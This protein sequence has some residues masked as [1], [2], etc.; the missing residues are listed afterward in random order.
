MLERFYTVMIG[1]RYPLSAKER[2]VDNGRIRTYDLCIFIPLY[3]RRGD[4][5]HSLSYLYKEHKMVSSN[6]DRHC[7]L[8]H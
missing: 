1:R 3:P 8:S 6:K 2:M 4:I 7:W 5:F